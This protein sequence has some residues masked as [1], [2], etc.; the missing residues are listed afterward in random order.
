MLLVVLEV[1]HELVDEFIVFSRKED[2]LYL[3]LFVL[4]CY[5]LQNQ[6]VNL[7]LGNLFPLHL[8]L[9][10]HVSLLLSFIDQHISIL[11]LFLG[12]IPSILPSKC[13]VS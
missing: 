12:L 13:L 9:L 1:V 11:Y 5:F 3:E 4:S 7:V 2:V 10:L 6:L 8:Q